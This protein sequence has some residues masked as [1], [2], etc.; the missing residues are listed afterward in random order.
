MIKKGAL[1]GLLIF[2]FFFGAGNLIFPPNL[3]YLSGQSFWPA[4]S[5]FILSGVGIAVLALIIGAMNPKGYAYELDRK[6]SPVFANIF[7]ISLYLAIGPFFA[8]PRTAATSFDIAIKN[9]LPAG[10]GA[11][12]LFAYTVL[13]FVAAYFLAINPSKILDR[14]GRVMTPLFAGSIVIL[15]LLGLSKFGAQPVG[16]AHDAYAVSAFGTGFLEGYSTLDALASVAFS[17][18]IVHSMKQLGFKNKREYVSI[19]W[20][21]GIVVA[22]LFSTL[23]L[24]LSMLGNH[25]SLPAEVLTNQD[26]HNGVYIITETTKSIFGPIGFIFLAFMVIMT[27]FTTTVGLLVSLS[28]FLHERF[29]KVNYKTC[30]RVFTL[31]GFGIANLGLSSIISYSV[32][33]L[34]VLYPITITFVIILMLNKVVA[35]SKLGIQITIGLVTIISFLTALAG[36]FNLTSLS[37]AIAYLPFANNSLAWLLPAILGMFLSMILPNRSKTEVLGDEI[38]EVDNEKAHEILD[39]H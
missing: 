19:V 22:L 15:V 11:L 4:I 33:V 7:L 2:G 16:Q 17:V 31:V 21:V 26:I 12:G 9:Y 13:Y 24:G 1:I 30:V 20:V 32:P 5:G 10:A 25:F 3:G 29:E 34:Q 28:G 35:M 27:C 18:T 37:A 38:F 6:V 14:I 39:P 23:Y 8:I 36:L